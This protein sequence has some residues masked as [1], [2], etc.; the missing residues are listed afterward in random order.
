MRVSFVRRGSLSRLRVDG[1][2]DVVD[3]ARASVTAW[4]RF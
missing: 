3:P 1:V 2:G 4:E